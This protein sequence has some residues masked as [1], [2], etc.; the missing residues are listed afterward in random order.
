[1]ADRPGPAV[2][3]IPPIRAFADALVAGIL[4]QHG[5]DRLALARGM[6]L[7]PN[8]RAGQ[9]I[10]E[11]FVRQAEG[12]LLLPR[13]VAVGDSELDEKAGVALDAIDDAPLPPAIE[14]LRRQLILARLVQQDRGIDG[15]EA[16]RLAAD[17][18][19]T[20]DQLIVE[21][22]APSKLAELN[23]SGELS[24]HWNASLDQMKAIL[25]LWPLE[26]KRL[27]RIDM[28]DR[29]NRQ[30]NR[31]AER[32]RTKP[33]GT[34]VIAAGIS[35][36]APAV[37]RLL[38]TVARIPHG[39]V[40]L[41]G[42]DLDISDEE[43]TAIGGGETE[44]AIE[45]HPQFH[46]YQLLQRMKVGRGEVRRWK[47]S[48]DIASTAKRARAISHA[49][50]PAE[51]TRNWV[52]LEQKD[53]NLAG[54]TALELANPAEE[55][56]AIAVAIRHAIEQPAQTA[57]LITPDRDLASRVSAHLE[58]WKIQADDSAGQSL[59]ASPNGTLLLVLAEALAEHFAPSA[60]LALLKHPLVRQGEE[61]RAWLDQVRSLDL[62]LRG[63][64]PASGLGGVT[65][66]LRGGDKRTRPAR[67]MLQGWWAEISAI[68]AP[69]E[70][71]AGQDFSA[72]IATLRE[73]AGAL[74]GDALWSG[75]AGREL[76]ALVAELEQGAVDGPTAMSPVSLSQVLR[77]LMDGIAI[78]PGYGG[79]P[80]VFIWGLLEA[81]L[82]SADVV[83]LGG[84]NEGTWPQLPAPDPWLAP[85]IRRELGLP[86]LE[87]RIGLAAH[88]LA[89]ALGAPKV[90]MTRAKRDTRSPTIAS[91]FWLRLETMT[92]VLERPETRYDRIAHGVDACE[93]KPVRAS[94]PA[95]CPP[96]EE[97]PREISVTAVDRL[98][99]DP[100]AFYASAMLGLNA[101]EPVDADPGPAWRGSLIHAVL[102]RWAEDDDYRPGALVE[103]MDKALSDG[104][105]HPLIRAL[106]LPRLSE[107]AEWIEQR[108]A[109]NRA[110]GRTPLVAEKSGHAEFAG[111]RVR[112]RA[113]RIDRLAD[114]RLAIVDY[115][116]GEGPSNRQVAAGFAMQLGLIGLI[117]EQGGFEG[118][119]GTAGAFEYWSLARDSKTGQF[120]KV[121]SP[122][123]GKTAVKEPEA[124]VAFIAEKFKEAAAN[125]LTGN[126]PF[127]AKIRP[128]YAWA[129]YDQLMRLE[130]WQG[131]DV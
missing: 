64:R 8:N 10:R 46:L 108:V 72:M 122:V 21:E 20:L 130:E 49:F 5:K 7:V 18:A 3:T 78:R 81:K 57:A 38:A 131:R 34:F 101:L 30:L 17:L 93:G 99:A 37:A 113:D 73:A 44:P 52:E 26:L 29:R 109:G 28:A 51:A 94:R 97:R 27:G 42:L 36:A 88:D 119:K 11:A 23:L 118:A 104:T 75:P 16:M 92:G 68:L 66:F 67:Q 96:V 112:G 100:F 91:R 127:K 41:A 128:E 63:P 39:Q 103:R 50:A 61:R 56:Q 84:L 35:T 33:P 115:K 65:Q 125:W 85:R 12:G 111:V 121:T 114:G 40:V 74:A 45:T 124:F 54:V 9:A 83:I 32:W 22:I 76:A 55:A 98:S 31:V 19:R 120:G 106:W 1:M 102:E 43:W 60:L 116:T 13:L 24:A 110:E 82:Q 2:Y 123:T 126:A 15:A 79:H 4:A 14:P 80:R 47:W 86:S 129:D 70:R 90:L 71:L 77:Q 58:R 117:A 89:S 87:R 53:R 48:G 69:L 62:V 59:A 6:I 107:A 25:D 95:P 105:I